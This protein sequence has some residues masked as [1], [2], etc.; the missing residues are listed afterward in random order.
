MTR[1]EHVLYLGNL[2]MNFQLLEGVLRMFLHALP[3]ERLLGDEYAG[4]DI[5][6]QPVGTYYPDNAL[7]N[8]DSL[9]ELIKKFNRYTEPIPSPVKGKGSE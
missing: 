4:K 8:Y 6:A 7:T 9:G 2:M 1:D 3:G 5:F